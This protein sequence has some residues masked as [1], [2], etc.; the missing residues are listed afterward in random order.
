MTNIARQFFN[1]N[2][3]FTV[4][5]GVYSVTTIAE[6]P[7]STNFARCDGVGGKIVES[8][9]LGGIA[10]IRT[11]GSVYAWG[12]NALGSLGLGAGNSIQT[13]TIVAGSITSFLELQGNNNRMFGITQDGLLYGT[14]DNTF[15][16]LG[17]NSGTSSFG[18]FQAVVVV[19]R[20]SKLFIPRSTIA[21]SG[22]NTGIPDQDYFNSDQ[23]NP[24]I[25]AND[26]SG[27]LYGWGLNL[28]GQLGVGSFTN[29]SSPN[30]TSGPLTNVSQAYADMGGSACYFVNSSGIAYA[31]GDNTYGQLG[32]NSAT[33]AF[34]SPVAIV[35]G[36]T[37]SCLIPNGNTCFGLTANGNLYGWGVNVHGALG[38]NNITN[39]SS[40]VLVSSL[41]FSKV[42]VF[43]SGYSW[44]GLAT[45]GQIWGC[46]QNYYGLLSN[47]GAVDYSTPVQISGGGTW[48][49]LNCNGY[50]AHAKSTSGTLYAWG[51]N[52]HGSLGINSFTPVSSPVAVSVVSSVSKVFSIPTLATYFMSSNG[53]CWA[54]G[55]NSR[56]GLGTNQ[57]SGTYP[58]ISTPV[59]IAGGYYFQNLYALSCTTSGP[60]IAIL[61][62]TKNGL[63]TTWGT[64][65]YGQLGIG[66]TTDH[67]SPVV[68]TMNQLDLRPIQDVR[69]FSVIPGNTYNV[70]FGFNTM[71]GDNYIGEMTNKLTIEFSQ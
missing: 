17:C 8:D 36:L 7:L 56:G 5:A 57:N 22:T 20:I 23:G 62:I 1:G 32:N 44:L 63:T 34:S 65:T 64:N 21:N 66:S 10:T 46:G 24:T 61:G 67:S 55:L 14:G 16:C 30:I 28:S 70:S 69:K 71:F 52:F 29:Q 19:N 15:G 51:Q 40:P 47:N 49:Y 4:P 39:Y 41:A 12:Y 27:T 53:T 37:F 60:G 13:P 48:N 3:T 9:T 31:S 26:L 18:S 54:V 68:V 43:N 6:R 59:L 42:T 45:N 35:G 50:N 2:G 38:Q 25:F 11:D 33:T 58:A